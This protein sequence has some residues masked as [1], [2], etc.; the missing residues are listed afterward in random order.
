ML[1][2]Q[3]HLEATGN[4]LEVARCYRA[5][6]D[7]A[8]QEEQQERQR[9]RE[10]K[11]A[12]AA[13][14]VAKTASDAAEEEARKAEEDAKAKEQWLPLL[15]S[16][17][18][19]SALT[20]AYSTEHGT[21]SDAAQLLAATAN[22]RRVSELPPSYKSLLQAFTTREIIR[23]S[24]FSASQAREMDAMP[25]VFGKGTRV[26]D[27]ARKAL[28]Q[29]CVEHNVLVVA[30][31]YTRIALP[32][33]AQ[34]LDLPEDEAEQELARLV[35]AKAVAARIDRPRGVV[36]FAPVVGGEGGE[37]GVAASATAA[38]VGAGDPEGLLNSWAGNIG[39]LLDLVDKASQQI[40]KEC[41]THKVTLL[42]PS[43][44]G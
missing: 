24:A 11:R 6:L 31:Y 26:G 32:R 14:G 3:Y 7:K 43:L 13:A 28:Q 34:L 17:A 4:Y 18:W 22:D 23:W 21:G 35:V 44:K 5:V 10:E 36:T 38:V 29:R 30:R 40:Q 33:L 15:K 37:G 16:A 20:P 41:M 39:K 9:E 2:V 25:A 12:A 42:P 8:P 1:M 19:Y 27:A